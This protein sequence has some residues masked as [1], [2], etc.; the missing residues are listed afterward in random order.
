MYFAGSMSHRS[1]S[2]TA[3]GVRAHIDASRHSRYEAGVDGDM[4]TVERVRTLCWISDR[5]SS[6]SIIHFLYD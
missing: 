4:D 6:N 2:A 1:G 5:F 3:H